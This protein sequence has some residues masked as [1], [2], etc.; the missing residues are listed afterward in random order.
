MQLPA[1]IRAYLDADKKND[2]EAVVQTF[3]ADAVVRD[4]GHTHVGRTAI[5]K[6]WRDAKARYQHRVE[7]V[8]VDQN[9][10]VVNVSA[11]VTGD[12]PGSPATLIFAFGCRAGQ[13]THLDIGV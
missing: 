12:F 4:E 8:G 5:E 2:G 6:W 11:K 3:A 1:P 9:G 10:D 7:P 13:I